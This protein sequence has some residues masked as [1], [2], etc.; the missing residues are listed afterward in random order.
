MSYNPIHYPIQNIFD[1][2]REILS[3]NDG[4]RNI[5]AW[6]VPDSEIPLICSEEEWERI[7]QREFEKIY[8]KYMYCRT[9]RRLSAL[10]AWRSMPR[11]SSTQYSISPSSL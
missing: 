1:S 3:C 6:A 7:Q 5:P 9:L 8:P 4:H 10:E 2:S 11:T